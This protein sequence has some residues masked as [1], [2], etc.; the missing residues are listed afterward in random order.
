MHPYIMAL[1][2]TAILTLLQ[3]GISLHAWAA[4]YPTKPVR[5]IVP[6]APGG[7]PEFKGA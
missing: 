7:G 4:D 2:R 6:S 1:G 5:L 3:A